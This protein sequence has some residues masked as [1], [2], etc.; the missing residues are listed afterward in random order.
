MELRQAITRELFATDGYRGV[1]QGQVNYAK[2]IINDGRDLATLRSEA[3]NIVQ[4]KYF[5]DFN[6]ALQ[7]PEYRKLNDLIASKNK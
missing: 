5:G 7:D 2:H 3:L 6:K 1:N 4:N